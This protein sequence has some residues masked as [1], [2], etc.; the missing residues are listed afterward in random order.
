M[1]PLDDTES[2][3]N[4]VKK[5]TSPKGGKRKDDV[6]SLS[7]VENKLIIQKSH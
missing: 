6:K 4:K 2:L 7:M 1:I 5:K 3:C